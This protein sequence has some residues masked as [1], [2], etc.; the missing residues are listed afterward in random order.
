[1]LGNWF[2]WKRKNQWIVTIKDGAMVRQCGRTG[3]TEY[4]EFTTDSWLSIEEA[5]KLSMLPS[6]RLVR[7]EVVRVEINQRQ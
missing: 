5:A 6:G 2:K 7:K 1:M 4:R 3:K